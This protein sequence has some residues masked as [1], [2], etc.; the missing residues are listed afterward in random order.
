MSSVLISILIGVAALIHLAPVVGLFSVSRMEALYGIS[1]SDPTTALLMRHRALLFG[2]VGAVMA[3]AAVY[4]PWQTL[5]I[6]LGLVSAVSFL[7][8]AGKLP[9]LSPQIRKVCLIDWVALACLI[10]AA[11][12]RYA[13]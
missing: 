7:L 2:L 6:A 13:V 11:G 4:P 10:L 3:I 9:D 1:I 5:A 12:L 8:L